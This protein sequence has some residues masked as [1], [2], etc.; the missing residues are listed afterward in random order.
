M[1]VHPVEVFGYYCIMYCPPF[2]PG[3]TLHA[4]SCGVYM[5]ALGLAGVLDHSGVRVRL[6]WGVYDTAAHDLHHERFNVNYGFPLPL[7][8]LLCGTFAEK[9]GGGAAG[10]GKDTGGVGV[11]GDGQEGV[12]SAGAVARQHAG[13]LAAPLNGGGR[14]RRRG[15]V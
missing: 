4:A 15:K 2:L 11:R 6:P 5:A 9:E 3:V 12:E 14:A 1:Y 13:R 8:D 10:M 7:M